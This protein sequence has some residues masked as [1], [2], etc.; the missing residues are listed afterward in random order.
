MVG[1]LDALVEEL[2]ETGRTQQ[3]A[4]EDVEAELADK[5][6]ILR[7]VEKVCLCTRGRARNERV[8]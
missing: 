7:Y 6:G 8:V 4:L 5:D 2:R 3:Q 1:E